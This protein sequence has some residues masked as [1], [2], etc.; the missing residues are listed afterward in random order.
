MHVSIVFD[1]NNVGD[2]VFFRIFRVFRV[3]KAD[4][5]VKITLTLQQNLISVNKKTAIF[6]EKVSVSDLR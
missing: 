1:I 3:S 5:N 2:T 4:K 6:T